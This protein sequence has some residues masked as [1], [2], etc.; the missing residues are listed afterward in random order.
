MRHE[1]V[2]ANPHNGDH[3]PAQLQS[4]GSL[5]AAPL[6]PPNLS[7]GSSAVSYTYGFSATRLTGPF[8]GH[9]REEVARILIQALVDL[10]YHHAA[11]VLRRESGYELEVP[12]VAAFRSA[13]LAGEWS[14]AE[15]I[16]FGR[17][18]DNTPMAVSRTSLSHSPD[19]Y[20]PGL[21]LSDGANRHEMLFR[22]RQQKY[23]EL[24]EHG[25]LESAL[26]VLRQELTPL[27]QDVS[28]LHTL[29]RYVARRNTTR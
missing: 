25:H 21:P 15:A 24:L 27:H 1:D 23:L 10:D 6:S 7:N 20:S 9:D 5:V 4:N 12:S 3:G 29:S 2:A 14:E 18:Q 26:M 11:A 8:F 16:L 22:M 19:D 28:R 17:P 13:V